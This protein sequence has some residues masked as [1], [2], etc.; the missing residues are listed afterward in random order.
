MRHE[1]KRLY[2]K[3]RADGMY[4]LYTNDSFYAN[5]PIIDINSGDKQDVGDWRTIETD[6]GYFIHP[7]GMFTNHSCDPT[8]FVHKSAGLLLT[9]RELEPD[10]EI[11]FDYLASETDLKANFTCNCGAHNCFGKIGTDKIGG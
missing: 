7:E 11:T 6:A 3:R 10:E 1:S 5:S 8:C 9:H 4:G 2:T